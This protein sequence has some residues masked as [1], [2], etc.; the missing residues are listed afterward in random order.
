MNY[1]GLQNKKI[2]CTAGC[3]AYVFQFSFF[4]PNLK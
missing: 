4:L 1:M 3:A 2:V